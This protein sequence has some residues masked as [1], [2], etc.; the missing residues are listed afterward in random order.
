MRLNRMTGLLA[1]GLILAISLLASP[2][3][4]SQAGSGRGP[5]ALLLPQEQTII[6]IVKRISPAVVAVT[7]YDA[8]GE[9]DAL[10]SGVIVSPNG[11]I[12]TNNHVISGASKLTVTLADG[13]EIPAKSLGGDPGL[14]IA[15]LKI[16][17]TG[18][19]AASL[20]D[21]D[22]L[23]VGQIAIAIGNPYGFE[24]TVTVG[25]VS[26]LGRN[27]P[28]GGLSLS[29]L[30]ETDAR[31]YPG[32]SGGPLLDSSGR[33]IGVT[34]AVV[35]GRAGTLGFAIPINTARDIM[36]DV[37]TVGRV[38]VP[39]IGISYGEIT[40]SISKQFKLQTNQ[41][42]I[43][44]K[45]EKNS[46]AALAGIQK[47]DIII[48]ADGRKIED[49]GDLQKAIRETGVGKPLQIVVLRDGKRKSANITISEMPA[50]LQ[51]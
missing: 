21:S 6:D 20:G 51:E 28:G 30:I 11:D 18:L 8:K 24:R 1:A 22:E 31:I 39:W 23:Q 10:G 35:G 19:P 50:G 16:N 47:S 38:V 15:I 7:N 37:Q 49:G 42:I 43:V 41:G 48:E 46:P 25:V 12:L 27:I 45:V 32:N 40:D 5:A 14:D 4:F 9:A 36:K 33:V 26:A 13:R 34:T 2:L 29:N 44:S 3:A 17:T